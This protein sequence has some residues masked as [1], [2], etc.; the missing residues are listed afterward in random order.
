[1]IGEVFAK[2]YDVDEVIGT[3][4]MSTVYRAHDRLLERDV[5][6]KVLHPHFEEDAEQA[7]RFQQ[8]ARAVAQLS[9][10]NIV[11]V[12]DRGESDGRH[13]IVFECIDG[14]SLKQL[15]ARRGPLPVRD[16]VELVL[17][18]ADG[19]AFA[20]D[21]GIVH[22]DVK[23]QNVLVTADG[24]A[25]VTDFGIARSLDGDL[26]MTQTGTVLGTMSYLSP[27]QA[28][29][30][31]VTP[32]TDIYSLGVVLFELLTGGVPF[33]G[34]NFVTVAMKVQHDPPPPL[35]ERRPDVPPRLAAAVERA[36]AKQPAERFPSMAAFADELRACLD[37]PAG[38]VDAP[39]LI[40]RA[41]R[42]RR[43]RRGKRLPA[44]LILL[45]L[46]A[47]LA[48]ASFFLI[49]RPKGTAHAGVGITVVLHGVTAYDP[50]PGDGHEH[51]AEAPRATDGKP[52]TYWETEEYRS[53]AFGGLKTGV[54]LVLDAGTAVALD[55]LTV[56]TDT[57]G[58][59]AV[60]RAGDTPGGPFSDDSSSQTV[61]AQTTF[62]LDGHT[63][64]FYVVWITNLGTYASV[65]V[66][67]V[68]AG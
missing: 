55:K 21:H 34:D 47:A 1:V 31:P 35:H 50:P 29:G 52:A 2:R 39:T 42:P 16:A 28:R 53:A 11:T 33:P 45:G 3:G 7:Q 48:A 41:A 61:A 4:G 6:L 59:T 14:E 62:V 57:P 51:N 60:I 23:P 18:V 9:H 12:I 13:F 15:A 10:P 46:V 68:K 20:H 17:Q 65:H 67:E 56:S 32:S 26:S 44:V 19:L 63:A 64:R 8:E 58:Y 40:K 24:D 5:A 38:P 54:G 25:K 37:R 30:E 49:G 36:L 66:N 43:R 22:R 27:E